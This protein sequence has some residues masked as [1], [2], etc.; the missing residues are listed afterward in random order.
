MT[1]QFSVY[2]DIASRTGGEIFVGV[3]GPVRTGKSTFVKRFVQELIVPQVEGAKKQR[4]V[5]ELPQSAA[6][7]TV[8]TTEPKF[9][10]EEAATIRVKEA[11]A[12]V[13]LI[14]CVGYP[15]EGATGF[16]EEGAPRLVKTPWSESPVPFERAAEEGTRK[17]IRDHS[18][19]AVLMTTDG[20]VAGIPRSAYEEAEARAAEELAAIGKPYVILLNC[21]SPDGAEGLRARLEEKYGVP[22]L[23]VNAEE[24]SAEDIA[25]VLE[26]I[27]YEFPVLSI[28]VD[29]PDWMRVLDAD[30][31]LISE[32]L[33]G[34]REVAPRVRKMSDCALFDT[35]YTE[36]GRLL[37]PVDVQLDA[38]T[39]RATFRVGAKDGA[40][41]EVLCE[42]C[43]ENI[44]DDFSLMRYVSQ[45]SE[46][47]KVYERVG[48]AFR[49]AQEYGY[50]IVPP[51]AGEM[52]LAQPKVVKKGG[53]VG[54]NLH[55]DAPSYHVIRVDVSGEVRPA[56]G[57]EEQSKAF[58]DQ[59][60]GGM[61]REPEEVWN[62]NMFGRTLKDIL[63]EELFVKNRSMGEN[64]QKKMRRTV[65]RIVNEG[66]GGVIC[67]LL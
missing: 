6:G 36:S 44:A 25:A 46:A 35:L 50:G 43:G 49:D 41:Y 39:G 47:K 9:V 57:G 19:I 28:D 26:R 54:V 52:S 53:R 15:V 4:Y 64:V 29:L 66:K 62:T 17:V 24:L 65:T 63:G 2:E 23:A 30:S 16:E 5:D 60:A 1:E 51:E 13:R 32:V 67:I 34:I 21:V 56:L 38:A 48:Q 8:M 3:V 18:T 11:V 20:S 22:V 61:E 31:P 12:K 37:P 7:K 45:L 14:D 58:V 59:L 55:A 40:F 42:Q 33:G 27:L 10:P